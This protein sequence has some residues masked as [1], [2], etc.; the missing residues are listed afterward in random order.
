MRRMV[1]PMVY[2]RRGN[3]TG[4]LFMLLGMLGMGLTDAT[5]K[6]LVSTDYP[7]YCDP[8]MVYLFNVGY[9]GASDMAD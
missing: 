1:L 9:V 4:I 3:L 7:G 5:A 2:T 6:W 8:G